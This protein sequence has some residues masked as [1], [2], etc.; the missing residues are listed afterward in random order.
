MEESCGSEGVHT[1]PYAGREGALPIPSPSPSPALLWSHLH[2]CLGLSAPC[3]APPP[4][5]A[6]VCGCV[7]GPGPMLGLVPRVEQHLAASP[8]ASPHRSPAA[9]QAQPLATAVP[10]LVPGP[11]PTCNGGPSLSPLIPVHTLPS[12]L[13]PLSWLKVGGRDTQKF[14]D[15]WSIWFSV[16]CK[17]KPRSSLLAK[18]SGL[19]GMWGDRDLLGCVG[20]P[21]FNLPALLF[22]SGIH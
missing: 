9:P 5:S 13:Q 19:P 1:S 20:E 8:A 2:L 22:T 15:H 10:I 12:K 3:L 4:A 7:P 17:P 11:K 18:G 16:P 21:Q 6:T 14:G